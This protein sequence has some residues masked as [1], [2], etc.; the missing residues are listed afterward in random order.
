MNME[1]IKEQALA[2]VA[3]TKEP[4]ITDK[5]IIEKLNI[6][7]QPNDN[8]VLIKPLAVEKIK[9]ELTI[10]DE[11]K[12]KDL[13]PG[14][15]MHTKKVTR[16]VETDYRKGVLLAAGSRAFKQLL[17]EENIQVGDT[18][19][20]HKRLLDFANFDLFKDS[21]L[22]NAYDIEAKYLG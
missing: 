22:C 6:P 5:Q 12:N 4:E 10:L 1:E 7:F 15:E 14:D 17:E 8:K 13:K 21:I 18:I 3:D 16:E 9:K 11:P 20:F 19:I 2:T